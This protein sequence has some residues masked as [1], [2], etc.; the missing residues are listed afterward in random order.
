MPDVTQEVIIEEVKCL[1]EIMDV[2]EEL[3]F[4]QAVFQDQERVMSH[5][6]AA[7]FFKAKPEIA[8]I[9]FKPTSSKKWGNDEKPSQPRKEGDETTKKNSRQTYQEWIDANP[10]TLY[11]QALRQIQYSTHSLDHMERHAD[12]VE[13]SV[14]GSLKDIIF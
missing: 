2:R 7:A 3:G 8:P 11:D 1:D 5:V 14:S 4:M 12:E 10:D 6:K 13:N 9:Q